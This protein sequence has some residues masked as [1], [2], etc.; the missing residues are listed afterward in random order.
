VS[1]DV[2]AS[3]FSLTQSV[4]AVQAYAM[5]LAALPSDII[6]MILQG[7][8][9]HDIAALS[10]TCWLLNSLVGQADYKV[11]FDC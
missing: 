4:G 3:C 8:S 9:A 11:M 10:R 6:I 5:T 1:D 7:L 2:L